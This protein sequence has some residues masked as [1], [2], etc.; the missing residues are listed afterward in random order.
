MICFCLHYICHV[1]GPVQHVLRSYHIISNHQNQSQNYIF[2]CWQLYRKEETFNAAFAPIKWL[3]INNKNVSSNIIIIQSFEFRQYQTLFIVSNMITEDI[4]PIFNYSPLLEC[5]S[6][7]AYSWYPFK[8]IPNHIDC[9]LRVFF[10]CANANTHSFSV[11]K[12]DW[13][14]FGNSCKWKVSFQ[15]ER[16]RRCTFR[17]LTYFLHCLHVPY[18]ALLLTFIQTFK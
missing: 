16:T 4:Q 11:L 18:L 1:L 2:I 13:S 9:I 5:V 15:C 17:F 7:Y 6:S 3:N 10:Q 8:C 12:V 14:L